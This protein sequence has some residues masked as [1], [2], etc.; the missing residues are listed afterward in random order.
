MYRVN[1]PDCPDF[2]TP[3]NFKSKDIYYANDDDDNPSFEK[4]INTFLS[5]LFWALDD[6]RLQKSEENVYVIINVFYNY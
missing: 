1:A 3:T 5:S 2:S 4:H 6:K